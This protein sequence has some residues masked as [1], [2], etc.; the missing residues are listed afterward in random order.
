MTPYLK[1]PR[2]SALAFSLLLGAFVLHGCGGGAAG[3]DASAGADAAAAGMDSGEAA[4]PVASP[5]D[6]LAVDIDG[7]AITV[8]Y[9]RPSKRGRVVF[10]GLPDMKWGMVWRTGAN[11]ATAFTTSRDLAFG[12]AVVPAGEYTLFTQLEENLAW[13]LV[14]SRETGQWGTEYDPS[15]DLVRI[16][17]QVSDNNPVVETMEI[18]VD[19]SGQGGD[20]V[21]LWDS[22]KA[23]AAFTV[24]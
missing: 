2:R 20:L 16:P 13:Q 22:Y 10:G 11:E 5:R 12:D 3:D 18:R 24:R 23:V 14:V 1:T 19:P 4:A 15:Q 17:M 9:G 21:V 6:S 7:A 8:N